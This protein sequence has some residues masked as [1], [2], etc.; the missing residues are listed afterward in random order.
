LEKESNM[1]S[2]IKP[3]LFTVFFFFLLY[4]PSIFAQIH[5]ISEGAFG[6][7]IPST[8]LQWFSAA[9]SAEKNT[10]RWSTGFEYNSNFFILEKS[11]NGKN[12]EAIAARQAAGLSSSKVNYCIL[13]NSV[14][15][16][17]QYYRLKY[18]D[19]DGSE[20]ILDELKFDYTYFA[21]RKEI[22][23][24]TDYK[25]NEVTESYRGPV[26][27]QFVDGSFERKIQ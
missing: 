12:Y 15:N 1:K 18:V 22:K 25:N 6:A 23:S 2:P 26:L 14:S 16:V 3:F 10:I 5:F 17:I 19:H 21:T 7:V 8:E 24:R 20:K 9:K 11:Y 4:H 13:D 27:I